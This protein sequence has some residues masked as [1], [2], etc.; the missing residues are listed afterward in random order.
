MRI[1]NTKEENKSIIYSWL[2]YVVRSADKKN[3]HSL[4]ASKHSCVISCSVIEQEKTM[5]TPSHVIMQTVGPGAGTGMYRI[6]TSRYPNTWQKQLSQNLYE[7]L[8]GESHK[9]RC[10][11]SKLKTLAGILSFDLSGIIN[12]ELAPG[13]NFTNT[14]KERKIN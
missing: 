9:G 14:D 13:S 6:S 5:K 10:C 1:R 3:K 7:G 2:M 11:S 12:L 8:Y 4:Q